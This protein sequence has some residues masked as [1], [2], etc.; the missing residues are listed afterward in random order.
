MNPQVVVF[1]SARGVRAALFGMICCAIALA[2]PEPESKLMGEVHSKG[3]IAWQGQT[4][5]VE[6]AIGSGL[7]ERASI[8]PDGSF[9]VRNVPAGTYR[10]SI[11][12]SQGGL[13][14][15]SLI[16]VTP[17]GPPLIIELDDDR[18]TSTNAETVSLARLRRKPSSAALRE[19]RLAE[20]ASSQNKIAEAISHL[21]RAVELA[22]DLQEARCNLGAKY[23]RT[24]DN[25]AAV[26]E[27]EA[28][29]A[30]DPDT[31]APQV[32]LALA[33][34]ALD[35]KKEAEEHA[36]AALRRDPLSAGANY[37]M[38]VVLSTQNKTGESLRYLDR[39][40]KRVPQALLIEARI[41]LASSERAPAISKLREYISRP[42]V[43]RRDEVQK[44]LNTI[45]AENNR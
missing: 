14:W 41:L 21:R 8:Q 25:E 42:G 38:G 29:V 12:D 1:F 20:K 18:R 10:V 17:G 13:I 15:Q 16:P 28:A 9:D 37:V 31:P 4:I 43:A 36:R 6:S 34:L 27:L 33:L 22:P 45:L 19:L 5:F 23:L 24:G 44:W 2:Q 3:P 11:R 7:K 40:S 30:L 32:N 26:R 35:R 39:A